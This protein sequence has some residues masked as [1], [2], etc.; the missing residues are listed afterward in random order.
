[1][2][3]P[4]K[5]RSL[6]VQFF[7]GMTT[8][9]LLPLSIIVFMVGSDLK[10]QYVSAA[11]ESLS[12]TN[13]QLGKKID[14]YHATLLQDMTYLSKSA[15]ELL[16]TSL[17]PEQLSIKRG[18]KAFVTVH[19]YDNLF[20]I[21]RR[22]QV[23]FSARADKV[24][25][26]NIH[27][28]FVASSP[29]A[30]TV[31][32]AITLK[33]TVHSGAVTDPGDNVNSTDMMVRPLMDSKDNVLGFLALEIGYGHAIPA[34]LDSVHPETSHS[35]TNIINTVSR[36]VYSSDA[37]TSRSSFLSS[38]PY[39]SWKQQENTSETKTQIATYHNING[40]SVLGAYRSVTVAGFK[41]LLIT[42]MPV[43]NALM[44]L[45][46]RVNIYSIVLLAIVLLIV[47][48]SYLMS[49]QIHAPVEKITAWLQL[50]AD[51]ERVNCYGLS[52]NSAIEKLSQSVIKLNNSYSLQRTFQQQKDWLLQRLSGLYEKMNGLMD[53]NELCNNI[54]HYLA[55][56]INAPAAAMY[57]IDQDANMVLM[58]KYGC[59]K[60]G[61]FLTLIN[62]EEG[63]LINEAAISNKSIQLNN[64]S[65]N[66]FRMETAHLDKKPDSVYV[67]PFNYGSLAKGVMVFALIKGIKEQHETFLKDAAAPIASAV[68]SL[69]LTLARTKKE[70]QA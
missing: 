33:S 63:G 70:S 15:E 49:R 58:G 59:P 60:K 2:P 62:T 9:V 42:E 52:Q 19:A 51:G 61:G 25:G 45:R 24:S 31:N 36:V 28:K 53:L 11:K 8:V 69:E 40:V 12:R 50:I 6:M 46:D 10:S 44:P 54:T 14:H 5:I 18:M 3:R 38:T 32:E 21:N 56:H 22:G 37:L 7:L 20:V 65:E 23:I 1:M 68:H 30:L 67:M 13:E 41:L 57:L 64:V 34:I 35:Q 66:F 43:A 29:L 26:K 39:L 16:S 55:T 27:D 47:L 4:L 17:A 48:L